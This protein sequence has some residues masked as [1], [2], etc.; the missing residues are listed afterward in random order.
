MCFFLLFTRYFIGKH[1]SVT[2]GT[3]TVRMTWWVVGTCPVPS[4]GGKSMSDADR[5]DK[6]SNRGHTMMPSLEQRCPAKICRLCFAV[7]FQWEVEVIFLLK[8]WKEKFWQGRNKCFHHNIELRRR[9]K[10]KENCKC[11]DFNK[12]RIIN[13]QRE[14]FHL[15]LWW[16][17][18]ELKEL[19]NQLLNQPKLFLIIDLILWQLSNFYF[20]CTISRR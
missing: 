14:S 9:L 1:T 19:L 2:L 12:K 5:R 11:H 6:T 7:D 16:C 15:S 18:K 13:N 17:K 8:D 10:H 20:Q 3:E 4:Y